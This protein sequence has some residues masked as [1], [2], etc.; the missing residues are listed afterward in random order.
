MLNKATVSYRYKSIITV[1][2]D[3]N[4]ILTRMWRNWVSLTLLVEMENF[5]ATWETVW[6]FHKDNKINMDLPFDLALPLWAFIPDHL[7]PV[8]TGKAVQHCSQ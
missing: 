3:G 8:F 7:K 1:K 2:K 6:Q 4:N 5:E